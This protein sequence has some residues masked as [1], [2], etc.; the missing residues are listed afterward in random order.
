MGTCQSVSAASNKVLSSIEDVQAKLTVG[1]H[2]QR[3]SAAILVDSYNSGVLHEANNPSKV[4]QQAMNELIQLTPQEQYQVVYQQVEM[5]F[6]WIFEETP[7][8]DT[9][10]VS[11]DP[12]IDIINS[13]NNESTCNESSVSVVTYVSNELNKLIEKS[14]KKKKSIFGKSRKL[15]SKRKNNQS[16]DVPTQSGTMSFV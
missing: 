15:F 7:E 1:N 11:G 10:L 9:S 6:G 16:T 14:K 4:V 13:N 5:Q 3:V 12:N 2:E 8:D